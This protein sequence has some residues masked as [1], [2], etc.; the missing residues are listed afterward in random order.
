MTAIIALLLKIVGVFF[1]FVAAIGLM[2]FTDA[3]QRM[4]AATKAGTLGAG[5]IV[6]GTVVS[7]WSTGST[8]I[9]LL[10]VIFLLLT[11]PVAGHMLGRAAYI[12]G[13]SMEGLRGEN[14]LEGVLDRQT[15]PLET[16][17]SGL[18]DTLV[19]TPAET[20]TSEPP[21]G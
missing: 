19:E 9:G 10:T 8:I 7:H 15:Q 5:L 3:F 13:A 6:M 16:R 11:V 17:L 20:E 21:K 1:L 18:A 4:H 14:A 12:S 2:R